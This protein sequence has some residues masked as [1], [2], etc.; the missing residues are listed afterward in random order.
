MSN[1]GDP[2]R[3]DTIAAELATATERVRPG[4]VV[5]ADWHG[6]AADAFAVRAQSWRRECAATE[7]AVLA[8]VEALRAHA[9]AMRAALARIAANERAARE[10]AGP[11]AHEHFPAGGSAA[12]LDERW[13]PR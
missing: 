4:P 12:W 13:A 9:G 8:V 3:V 10:A 5:A 7:P 1:Y 2:D 11:G 6:G